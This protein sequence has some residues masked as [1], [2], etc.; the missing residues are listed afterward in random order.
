M[1]RPPSMASSIGWTTARAPASNTAEAGFN[2]KPLELPRFPEIGK[3][4][5]EPTVQA[6]LNG[7]HRDHHRG[8][9]Q[10]HHR[11]GGV[12]REGEDKGDLMGEE[13]P[14]AWQ[15]TGYRGEQQIQHGPRL[16]EGEHQPRAEQG[17][18]GDAVPAVA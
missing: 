10:V 18:A 11:V 9:Y 7:C 16:A 14:N 8:R 4:V 6:D 3:R 13:G 12:V 15:R 17:P 2:C 5:L 1:P